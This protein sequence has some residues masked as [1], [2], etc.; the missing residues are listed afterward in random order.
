MRKQQ[1]SQTTIYIRWT[2]STTEKVQLEV[3]VNGKKADYKLTKSNEPLMFVDSVRVE[4]R[5]SKSV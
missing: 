4:K 5:C 2:T 1:E 3:L